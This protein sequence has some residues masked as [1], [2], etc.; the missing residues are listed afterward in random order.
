MIRLK[1]YTNSFYLMNAF[2]FRIKIHPVA[3]VLFAFMVVS[4]GQGTRQMK[5]D[6]E[7]YSMYL[8]RGNE[9][10]EQAQ[11]TLLSNVSKAM[12]QGGTQY[13]VEF[14]NLKVSGI[15]DTLNNRYNCEIY[16]ISAQNRNPENDLETET[17]QKLWDY[18]MAGHRDG[19]LHDTLIRHDQQMVYYKP[20]LTAMPACLQCHGPVDQIDPATYS[21]IRELYSDDKATGYELNELRGLWKISFPLNDGS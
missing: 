10:S 1:N 17:D 20:I 4:C 2:N 8:T 15:T 9:I 18:F 14:C 19:T 5:L 16:R 11:N 7:T 12:A 21:K 3:F 13:A 6:A